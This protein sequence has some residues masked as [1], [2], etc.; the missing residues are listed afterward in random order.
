MACS[1]KNNMTSTLKNDGCNFD[2][3]VHDAT[4]EALVKHNNYVQGFVAL[5]QG[6]KTQSG[7]NLI[8]I[9]NE[10]WKMAREYSK[11]KAKIF[12]EDVVRRHDVLQLAFP[13]PR[14]NNW[15]IEKCQQWLDKTPISNLDEITYLK[16]NIAEQGSA[17]R[18]KRIKTVGDRG[19][20]EE[21]D[22]ESAVST[23]D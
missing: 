23:T 15:T 2:S 21:L 20:W 5:C 4:K 1:D 9:D 3:D 6:L 22:W 13:K 7:H 18:R 10:P 17:W 11:P 8:N 14:S 12:R 16:D 19:S